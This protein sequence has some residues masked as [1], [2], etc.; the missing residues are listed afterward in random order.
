M[1]R[2]L[3]AE[4]REFHDVPRMMVCTGREGTL[5]FY[6]RF[7]ATVAR[8]FDHYEV[9][10]LPYQSDSEPCASWFG[11]ETR[12]LERLDDL[13]VREFPFDGERRAFLPYDSIAPRLRRRHEA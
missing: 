8:Y 2:W 1:P 7:D 13:P 5:L 11:L 10:R 12:A 9:Y 6:S 3:Q 4:Y